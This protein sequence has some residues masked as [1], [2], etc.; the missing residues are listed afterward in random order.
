MWM[1]Y[2]IKEDERERCIS[3]NCNNKYLIITSIIWTF[4][5]TF[6]FVGLNRIG[7]TD[8]YNY[9]HFFEMCNYYESYSGWM[10]HAGDD[11]AFKWINKMIRYFT[12]NYQIYFAIVY[13]FMAWAYLWFIARFTPKESSIIPYLLCFFLYWR[14]MNTLRSNLAIAF[15]MV[16]CVFLLD[17]KIKYAYLFAIIAT[18]THKAAFVF[19]FV[20]PFIQMFNKYKL[21]KWHIIFFV[22]LSSLAG[23]I[24]QK[25]F[26]S[27][28]NEM[29]LEGAYRSYAT[30]S[31]EGGGFFANAWKI[32]FE[33]LILG[34]FILLYWKKIE[35]LKSDVSLLDSAKIH[36]LGLICAYDLILIPVNYILN[37]WRGYEFFYMPRVAMWGII[38]HLILNNRKKVISISSIIIFLLFLFWFIFRIESM[39]EPSGLMP[40]IFEPTM[41]MISNN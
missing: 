17:K 18:L 32:A 7:G 9:I 10:L 11:I 38:C 35:N 12:G 27:F 21:E 33:Q 3:V 13:G 2:Y 23:G 37:I 14:S 25:S 24:L 39:F 41:N 34:F 20:I 30:S 15:I 22:M 29:D 5:A 6:R 26:I 1:I 28:T 19:V 16:A 31:I 36:I 4:F 40:Y 8:T